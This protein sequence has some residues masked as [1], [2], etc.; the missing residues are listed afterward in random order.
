ME[1]AALLGSL[2]VLITHQVTL[3][4]AVIVGLALSKYWWAF[5]VGGV[6]TA[7]GI[8]FLFARSAQAAL[9]LPA[10]DLADYLKKFLAGAILTL[11]VQLIFRLVT[12][13]R[14]N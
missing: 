1:F 8:E 3:V 5:A 14:A 9:G 12:R 6:L 7:L 10:S 4:V 2:A 13:R 11:I